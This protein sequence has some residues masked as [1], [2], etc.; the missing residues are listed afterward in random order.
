V[1]TA[2][3]LVLATFSALDVD[4]FVTVYKAAQ[5]SGRIF[6]ADAY[7]A[8][9]LYLI[10]RQA[11]VPLATKDNGIRVF[12][13]HLFER[14]NLENLREQFWDDRIGLEEV[15]ANP[16]KYV[17]VFRPSMAELDFSGKLPP[18]CRV[19]YGYW[20]GYLSKPDWVELQQQVAQAG[21]DF[22]PAHTSG[23][24][25][26]PDL[27]AFVKAVDAQ[28]VIPIHTFEPQMFQDHFS[29]VRLLDDGRQVDI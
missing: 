26:I 15:L 22:I 9:V 28:V 11:K 2:P 6:V 4:R 29:N 18:K 16:M 23:H 5:R 10:H 1:K 8:F 3:A 19:L 13:N 21:G 12:F 25:Y 20:K 7:T 14:R 27:I 24:I 17:M